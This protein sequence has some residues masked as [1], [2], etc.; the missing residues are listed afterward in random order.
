MKI[1]I[2][3][4]TEYGYLEAQSKL[5]IYSIRKFGGI[6]KSADIYSYSPRKGNSLKKSTI[7]FFGKYNVENIDLELNKDYPNYPLANKPIVCAHREKLSTADVLI[8]LDSDTF[9]LQSPD[10]ITDMKSNQLFMR[11]VGNKN[12]GTDILF[13]DDNADYWQKLYKELGVRNNS[14][15]TTLEDNKKIVEYYNSGM[16]ISSISDGLFQNWKIN[17]D[18]AMSLKLKPNR[19]IFFVEQSVLSATISAM[20][21]NVSLLPK[22]FNYPIKHI[23]NSKNSSYRIDKFSEV[24]HVHYHKIFMGKSINPFFKELSE[25][26]SGSIINEKLIEFKVLE[27]DYTNSHIL[28]NKIKSIQ[29]W[30]KRQ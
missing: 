3:I 30:L 16:I 12:I 13:S 26:E 29:H 22:E 10:F 15:V 9:F 25:F 24:S 11:P 27:G 19:G 2:I 7:D 5:L 14:T 28:K 18:R 8:F 4:C 23:G 21:I 17:F 20:N 6:L 1:E